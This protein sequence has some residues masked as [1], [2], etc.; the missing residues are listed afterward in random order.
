MFRKTDLCPKKKYYVWTSSRQI[1]LQNSSHVYCNTFLLEIIKWVEDTHPERSICN[2]F[3]HTRQPLDRQGSWNSLTIYHPN[4]NKTW[5]QIFAM[6]WISYSFFWVIPGRL[7]FIC[8]RFGTICPIEFYI[9]TNAHLYTTK[10]Q[11]KMFILKHLK[12]LQHVS[13]SFRSSSGS[14]YIPY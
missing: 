8:R 9:P 7:N 6:F 13:I 4:V 10:Y 14:S 11:S 2:P 5:L 12:R 3:S 1:K